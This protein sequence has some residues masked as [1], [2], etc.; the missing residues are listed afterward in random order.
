MKKD[1]HIHY[2]IPQIEVDESSN[3]PTVV[4][5][6]TDQKP[7]I[8]Q[9]ALSIA[10]GEK[11]AHTLIRNFKLDLGHID[12]DR[13]EKKRRAERQ[14]YSLPSGE[15][16][17][18]VAVT[19]DFLLGVLRHVNRWLEANAVGK[20][21]RILLA[22]PLVATEDD[23]NWLSNYRRNLL[24]ILGQNYVGPDLAKL[25]LDKAHVDFMPEPFAVFQYYRYGAKLP[26]L[27]EKKKII[28]LVMDFG[29]GTFDSCVIETTK[30]GD[31]SVSVRGRR[32][33]E[34]GRIGAKEVPYGPTSR[35]QQ[36]KSLA[37]THWPL[38]AVPTHHP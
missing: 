13:S 2:P 12:P 18:V 35:C 21:I 34:D 15:F 30:E 5:Y 16:K 36:T 20:G 19:S 37:R 4:Y 32:L 25:D 9:A 38:A 6:G 23:D 24:A 31:I 14:K 28:A 26:L 27:A 22:E 8:G 11:Q 17:S 7:V 1:L 33:V 10:Q 29:G 3:I